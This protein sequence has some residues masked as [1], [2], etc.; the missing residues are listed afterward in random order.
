MDAIV[1]IQKE[2]KGENIMTVGTLIE[3]LSKCNKDAIVYLHRK[4]GEPVL[5]TATLHNDEECVWLETESDV[6]MHE[7]ISTRLEQAIEE[8]TDELDITEYLW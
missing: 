4:D 1:K 6:D 5:F 8:G 3:K 7:E 2:N